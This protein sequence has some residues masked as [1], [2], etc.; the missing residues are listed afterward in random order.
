MLHASISHWKTWRPWPFHQWAWAVVELLWPSMSSP[1]AEIIKSF[2]I[3]QPH[4]TQDSRIQVEPSKSNSYI[5]IR[6]TVFVLDPHEQPYT[7]QGR[8]QVEKSKQAGSP[9]AIMQTPT[10]HRK[11]NQTNR[12]K[13]HWSGMNERD[14][15]IPHFQAE[16]SAAAAFPTP[17]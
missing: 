15:S 5:H 10:R 11:N 3:D 13:Q 7:M 17:P 4:C 16:H 8:E 1:A 14:L 9:N 6:K 12:T 2:H